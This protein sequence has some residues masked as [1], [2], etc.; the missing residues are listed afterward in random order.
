MAPMPLFMRIDSRPLRICSPE[1]RSR[2]ASMAERLRSSLR[3]ALTTRMFSMVSW[4][5][6]WRA[7][8]AACMR[9]WRRFIG[10]RKAIMPPAPRAAATIMTGT[11]RQSMPIRITAA[12][13]KLT[14][15]RRKE[16]S[17]VMTPFLTTPTSLK[18]RLTSSPL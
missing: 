8:S 18:T 6:A 12:P 11:K 1:R 2:S 5:L 15:V 3:E 16:G 4:V 14:P 10:S 7:S 13:I 17:M 9:L